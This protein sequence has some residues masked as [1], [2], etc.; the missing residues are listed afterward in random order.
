MK[1][2]RGT[3]AVVSEADGGALMSVAIKDLP[4]AY[5]RDH[6]LLIQ[7]R[8][9]ERLSL[10]MREGSDPSA[11]LEVRRYLAMPFDAFRP[12]A[13][14]CRDNR[15]PERQ[16]TAP[17]PECGQAGDHGYT[18]SAHSRNAV[19]RSDLSGSSGE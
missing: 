8:S 4:Y 9:G 7:D 17:R 16:S 11:L 10:A 3:E 14:R 1:I 18:H 12:T 6:G 15:V 2:A 19:H 13:A 5:A